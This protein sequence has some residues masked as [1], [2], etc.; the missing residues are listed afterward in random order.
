MSATPATPAPRSPRF[1]IL[2][3]LAT[4]LLTR[5][6]GVARKRHGHAKEATEEFL[7]LCIRLIALHLSRRRFFQ[8]ADVHHRRPYLLHQLGE[9][10]QAFDDGRTARLHHLRRHRLD[11]PHACE[12]Q[13]GT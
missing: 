2:V 7:H 1:Y 13:R 4:S 5:C 6:I 10:R 3:S 8:R 9:V 12:P 11:K